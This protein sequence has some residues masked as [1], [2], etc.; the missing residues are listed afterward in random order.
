MAE[1]MVKVAQGPDSVLSTE[2]KMKRKRKE[3]RPRT[4]LV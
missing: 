3:C 2:G 1:H 4:L